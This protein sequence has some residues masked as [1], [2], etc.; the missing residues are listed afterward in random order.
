MWKERLCCLRFPR[1]RTI[2]GVG[3]GD[4][5]VLSFPPSPRG[6]PQLLKQFAFGCCM[7]WAASVLLR[8][9]AMRCQTATVSPEHRYCCRWGRASRDSSGAGV[10]PAS[11]GVVGSRGTSFFCDPT[12]F[13]LQSSPNCR[14]SNTPWRP[15]RQRFRAN[16]YYVH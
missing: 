13:L 7:R 15:P 1:E 5:S 4:Y 14:S 8:A 16:R 6:R 2:S 11:F 3:L 9:P 10:P 12:Y